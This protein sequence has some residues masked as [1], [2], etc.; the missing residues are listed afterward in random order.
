MES[1]KIGAHNQHGYDYQTAEID[2]VVYPNV[3]N[4]DIAIIILANPVAF[5]KNIRTICLPDHDEQVYVGERTRHLGWGMTGQY[6]GV[7]SKLKEV[8]LTVSQTP[9]TKY[10]FYSEVDF[11]L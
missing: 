10:F 1:V 4:H 8:D 9:G 11:F 5:D 3:D 7:S 2:Q 6:Q